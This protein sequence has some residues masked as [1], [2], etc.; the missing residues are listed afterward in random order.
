M[1]VFS[2]MMTF[3]R[4]LLRETRGAFVCIVIDACVRVGGISFILFN[5]VVSAGLLFAANKTKEYIQSSAPSP[6][7]VSESAPI[8]YDR[9]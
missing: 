9:M 3:H 2:P 4:L 1:I 7:F 6:G 8:E 5:I